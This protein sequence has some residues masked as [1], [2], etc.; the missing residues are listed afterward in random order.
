MASCVARPWH[1]S[2][3]HNV[4]CKAL[5]A[6]KSIRDLNLANNTAGSVAVAGSAKLLCVNGGV[7]QQLRIGGNGLRS[8]QVGAL[9][10]PIHQVGALMS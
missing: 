2:Y 9:I 4:C 1:T 10:I 8:H 5:A 6:H 7:L 3:L